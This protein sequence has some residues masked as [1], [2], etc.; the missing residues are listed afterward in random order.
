MNIF[1]NTNNF[2][3]Q[4]HVVTILLRAGRREPTGMAR[5]IALSALG[6]FVYKEFTNR[7]FHPKVVD[8]INVLLLALKV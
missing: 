8:A 6:M 7:N 1:L 2:V 3:L 4:E 5:C